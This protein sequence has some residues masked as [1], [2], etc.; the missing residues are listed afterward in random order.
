MLVRAND[1]S[2]DMKQAFP[3]FVLV[4]LV[5]LAAA[6]KLRHFDLRQIAEAV[7]EARKL[8][9]L[10]KEIREDIAFWQQLA[11]ELDKVA[12]RLEVLK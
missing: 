3:A 5:F 11:A 8:D 4:V 10:R 1:P 7:A 6:G 9:R 2:I 12:R